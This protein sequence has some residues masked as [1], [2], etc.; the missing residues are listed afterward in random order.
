MPVGS[1]GAWSSTLPELTC[2]TKCRRFPIRMRISPEI[3]AGAK[4][5]EGEI[6]TAEPYFD[7]NTGMFGLLIAAFP[8]AAG[9][10]RPPSGVQIVCAGSG[11]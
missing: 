6:K 5:V 4:M 8:V 10:F 11:A 1:I 7:F 2:G 3:P 9:I